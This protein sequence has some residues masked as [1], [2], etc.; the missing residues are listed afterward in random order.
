MRV[1]AN[2]LVIRPA[3]RPIPGGPASVAD[4]LVSAVQTM[5]H[6]EAVVSRYARYTYAELDRAVDAAAAGFTHL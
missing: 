2:G 1:D 3:P 4:V 6:H 5:P